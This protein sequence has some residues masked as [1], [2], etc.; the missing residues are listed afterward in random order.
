MSPFF[1]LILSL[2]D[3]ELPILN[4]SNLEHLHLEISRRLDLN[5]H[6]D[7]SDRHDIF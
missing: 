7:S 6:K 4:E 1:Q 5:L 3:Y 2:L